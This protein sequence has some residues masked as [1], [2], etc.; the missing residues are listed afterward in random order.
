MTINVT[1]KDRNGV[2][3]QIGSRVRLWNWGCQ[4]HQVL[5]EAEVVW[6]NDEGCVAVDPN[7]ISDSYE[8]W[9]KALPRCEV[10]G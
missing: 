5:G 1:K 8:L 9:T 3:I 6:D 2:E 4:S 7:I 10:I